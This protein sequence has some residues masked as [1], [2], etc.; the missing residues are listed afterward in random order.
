MFII[1]TMNNYKEVLLFSEKK[2]L[3]VEIEKAT[4]L[5]CCGFMRNRN[6]KK[7]KNKKEKEKERKNKQ[8]H[9]EH[10]IYVVRSYAYVHGWRFGESFTKKTTRLQWR[11]TRLS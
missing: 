1:I 10:K 11:D 2:L 5:I 4:I 7:I 6:G 3:Y 9:G 8:S